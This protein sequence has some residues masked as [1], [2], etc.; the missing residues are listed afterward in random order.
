MKNLNKNEAEL[1]KS[2]AYEKSVYF[3]YTHNTLTI[4]KF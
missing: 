1:K 3:Q 4:K 2:V